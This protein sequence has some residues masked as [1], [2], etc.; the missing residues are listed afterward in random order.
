MLKGII[1]LWLS[2]Q[3]ELAGFGLRKVNDSTRPIDSNESIGLASFT[4]DLFY[5]PHLAVQLLKV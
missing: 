3:Y 4:I 5:S 1:I 2:I